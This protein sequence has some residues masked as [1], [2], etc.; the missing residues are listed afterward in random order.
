M[1]FHCMVTLGIVLTSVGVSFS[2]AAAQGQDCEEPGIAMLLLAGAPPSKGPSDARITIVEFMD[3][4]C[5][6]CH[7]LARW[8]ANLPPEE[9]NSIRIVIRQK[10]LAFHPWAREA[11]MLSAC[12]EA[13]DKR[14][15][16][17]LHDFLFDHQDDLTGENLKA[18]ALNFV[19]EDLHI[20]PGSINACLEHHG[21]E[22]SLDR[23]RQLAD[24]LKIRA[25]PTI[26]INGK[27]YEGFHSAEDLKEAIDAAMRHRQEAG[28]GCK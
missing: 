28:S 14:A 12:V 26:F 18:R 20:N 1:K 21:Y 6:H 16:W 9:A 2:G 10:P 17:K 25:T 4:E 11:A 13:Q 5:P 15:F 24:Q 3:F 22:A 23:D 8:A 7:D 27:R 19:T